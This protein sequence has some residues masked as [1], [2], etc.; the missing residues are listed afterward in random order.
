MGTAV[1][2]GEHNDHI[3][4]VLRIELIYFTICVAMPTIP[5]YI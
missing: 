4:I 3:L 2:F 5:L 1:S